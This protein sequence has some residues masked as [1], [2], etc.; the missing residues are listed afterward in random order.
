MSLRPG[1]VNQDRYSD[2]TSLSGSWKA[3]R[4]AAIVQSFGVLE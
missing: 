4:I 3:G 1:T 2:F